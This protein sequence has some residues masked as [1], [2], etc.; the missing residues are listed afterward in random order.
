MKRLFFIISTLLLPMC[1][2]SQQHE[3]MKRYMEKYSGNWQRN[4]K[5]DSQSDCLGKPMPDY[6]FSKT[7]NSRALQGK[8]V[9][10]TFWATWCSGCRLLC[11]DLDSVMVR[12]SDEYSNVQIIGVD[13]N[14]RLV[15]KGYVAS[16]FWEEK[17]IGYP[18]TKPGKAADQCAKSI[19]AGHPST[20]IIDG[21]GII[22]GRWDAWSPGLAGDVALAAWAIDVAPRQG[23]KADLPTVDRMIAEKHY[24][25]ALYL[26]E[27]MPLDTISIAQR[28][29][30]LVNVS[31][32]HAIELY[33]DLKKKHYNIGE[34]G[35]VWNKRPSQEYVAYMRALRDVVLASNEAENVELLKIARE[36]AGV[37]ANWA[38][39]RGYTHSLASSELALRHGRAIFSRS[40]RNLISS[41]SFAKEQ[42][43]APGQLQAIE[44]LMQK[45][46]I[47]EQEYGSISQDHQRMMRDQQEQE[48]KKAHMNKKR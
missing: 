9:V 20:V 17:D 23:I 48:E 30:A 3:A 38:A 36:A 21:E 43:S 33:N 31:P 10:M 41:R 22:R 19:K 37:V 42:K 46:G 12:H 27:Q 29:Q 39:D 11:V 8:T 47:T 1:L 44:A 34:T 4:A 7:L 40:A 35:E 13:A 18:T 15:D 6:S 28:W 25:R 32:R 26:L 45:Y 24:D 16:T 5:F 2:F 14:E